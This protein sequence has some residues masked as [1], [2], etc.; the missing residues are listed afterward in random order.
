[1][2]EVY[3]AQDTRLGR[4][5][6]IKF[7]P[8]ESVAD[9]RARQRLV[10]EARAAAKL[11]HPNICTIYDV[12]EEGGNTFIV[13]QYVEG[14][15]LADRMKRPP[16]ELK[17]SL[18][19][20][21]QVADALAEAHSHGIV[22][23]DIKPQ[24]IMI[25]P[26]R[27]VKVLDFGLAQVV[28][29]TSS[30]GVEVA[31]QSHLIEP[32]LWAG[33]A[34]YMSPEQVQG[35]PVDARC[36][37]FAFGAVLYEMLGGQRAF[38]G[39]S[40]VAIASAV[41]RD[42]PASLRGVPPELADIVRR[43]LR[44]NPVDRYERVLDVKSA[45]ER[46]RN[47]VGSASRE[48]E[49]SIA[50][51]PFANLS[52]DKENEY[53]SDG[54]AEEILNALSRLPGLKVTARTSAFAF[55]GK[56]QD[57]RRIG[58]ALDVRTVLE[59]SVRR[60]GNRIRV[61]VQ[62]INAADGYHL[63]SERYDREMTDV[64]AVQDEI[65]QAIVDKLKLRLVG[66]KTPLVRQAAS[67]EA[68][69]ANLKG[70]YHFFKMSPQELA[71]SKAYFEEAIALDPQYA[72]AYVG[73]ARCFL[74]AP[75]FGGKP[76]REVMPQGKAAA[77][78]AVQLDEREPEAHVLLG[79]VAGQF[80]YDWDE[81]L[82]RYRL[83]R[84]RE[85]MPS[86]AYFNCAQF[87]LMPLH[88]FDEAIALLEPALKADPLSPY[89]RVALAGALSACGSYDLAIQ[90]FHRLL[91]F[92]DFWFAHFNLGLIYTDKGM[93]PEAIAAWEKGLQLLPNYPP[94]IGA[95]AGHYARAGGRTR[96]ESLLARLA[97]PEVAHSCALGFGFYHLLCSEF[98]LAADQFE[99]AIEARDPTAIFL[100]FLPV[101]QG[102]PRRQAL[103]QK[104]N[105]GDVGP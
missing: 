83:A 71:H 87:I 93:V 22:H 82:R 44:K 92:E 26:R 75:V 27:Q 20:A 86:R 3:L 74:I 70:W 4:K 8:P 81:A 79:Q 2:G 102:L 40:I 42:E 36:D 33:T 99:K 68:Y 60:A 76:A 53:F 88:R 104:M 16:L 103:L 65:A 43:C 78:K 90:E 29:G 28:E 63:W 105:L 46:V 73:L 62:L 100:S 11:D 64:F 91:E 55:R 1:M 67:I 17:E 48:S 89:P 35:K 24:N 69:H 72:P 47:A 32:G 14:E 96:A 10:R 77:L 101:L 31:T 5:V 15:T 41:L 97:A 52:A 18:D 57:I 45:L 58:E 34:P 21:V 59:G 30:T 25:M 23:R 66:E 85:P 38:P 56:E 80:E 51:L 12:G 94:M 39:E 61:S 49:P 50:V 7:L 13:M 19:I 84:A 54:L 95:L 9:E 98:D 6:A 37:I